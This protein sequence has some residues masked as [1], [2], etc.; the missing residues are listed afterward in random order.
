MF[1]VIQREF[2]VKWDNTW[3]QEPQMLC[4]DL[5]MKFLAQQEEEKDVSTG[6]SLRQQ[7]STVNILFKME[8]RRPLS[9]LRQPDNEVQPPT[10]GRA[11]RSTRSEK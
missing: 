5:L 11:T 9:D 4:P 2:L 10:S 1:F 7:S 6:C 3:V 8:A